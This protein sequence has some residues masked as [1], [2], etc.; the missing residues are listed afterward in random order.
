MESGCYL[1]FPRDPTAAAAVEEIL[2][3]ATGDW[4]M[5]GEPLVQLVAMDTRVMVSDHG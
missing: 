5:H 2:G 4:E 1:K 3:E